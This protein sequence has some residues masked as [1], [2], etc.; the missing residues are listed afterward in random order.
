MNFE[1]FITAGASLGLSSLLL[2]PKRGFYDP[3]SGKLILVPQAT[4][5]ENHYDDME[6]TEHP[7]EQGANIADHAFLKPAELTIKCSWSN[8]PTGSGGILGMAVS[9]GAS[10]SPGFAQLANLSSLVQ[11]ALNVANSITASQNGEMEDQ[12]TAI[13]GRLL[14]MQQKRTLFDIYTGKRKYSNMLLKSVSMDNTFKTEQSLFVTLTC[15]QII[16]VNTQTVT[17]NPNTA[18]SPLQ[19]APPASL[20]SKILGPA[21][22]YTPIP[23]V[24]S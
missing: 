2:S 16:I 6:I 1:G 5:E 13:Y 3:N 7:V 18:A 10:I 19:T 23:G 15:R 8:S 22:N 4:I 11:G 24:T 20:G 14:A 12:V 21:L 9:A 17:I